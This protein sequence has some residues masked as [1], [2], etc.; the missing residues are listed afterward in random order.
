MEDVG[1]FCG[2][3][4]SFRDRITRTRGRHRPS[5]NILKLLDAGEPASHA[6]YLTSRLEVSRLAKLNAG[7]LLSRSG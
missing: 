1:M 2:A 5:L 3:K 6:P 7:F 4:L